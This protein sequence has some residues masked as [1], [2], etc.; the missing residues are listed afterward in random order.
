MGQLIARQPASTS[1][2]QQLLL[3]EI[4]NFES[5]RL[6]S[7]HE[8]V[9]FGE[10]R[11]LPPAAVT[12]WSNTQ[13]MAYDMTR[14]YR[15]IMMWWTTRWRCKLQVLFARNWKVWLYNNKKP[16]YFVRVRNVFFRTKSETWCH[17]VMPSHIFQLKKSSYFF[18]SKKAPIFSAQKS[19]FVFSSKKSSC[20]SVGY[21]LWFKRS[22]QNLFTRRNVSGNFIIYCLPPCL[23]LRYIHRFTRSLLLSRSPPS[24]TTRLVLNECERGCVHSAE[25][26]FCAKQQLWEEFFCAQPELVVGRWSCVGPNLETP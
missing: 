8:R 22:A 20:I 5:H 18:S 12:W 4:I 26:S 15:K 7:S 17:M 16:S 24:T 10:P 6:A 23:T 11:C 25:W 1:Q 2:P 21:F 14:V 9:S 3:S 13:S 19:P